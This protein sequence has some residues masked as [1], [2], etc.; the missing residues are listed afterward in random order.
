MD[1]DALLAELGLDEH[2]FGGEDPYEHVQTLKAQ[3]AQEHNE[4]VR[5][6]KA[7]DKPAALKHLRKKKDIDAEL[8][9]YLEIHPEAAYA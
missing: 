1:D 3:I 2:G 4:A 7:G 6:G 8:M 5:L 9:V